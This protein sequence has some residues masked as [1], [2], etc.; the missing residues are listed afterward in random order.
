MAKQPSHFV[1]KMTGLLLLLGAVLSVAG[2]SGPQA[3]PGTDGAGDASARGTDLA[4]LVGLDG[5]PAPV[6]DAAPV[7]VVGLGTLDAGSDAHVAVLED[8]GS[9]AHVDVLE[10]AAQLLEGGPIHPCD[11]GRIDCD[12]IA[13]NGCEMLVWDAGCTNLGGNGTRCADCSSG[14][15]CACGRLISAAKCATMCD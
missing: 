2:C 14:E 13:S 6:G 11:A 5:G 8:A 3:A 7:D 4:R 1:P 12:G 10:D 15:L 9:D